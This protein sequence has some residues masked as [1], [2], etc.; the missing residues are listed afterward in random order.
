MPEDDASYLLC[1]EDAGGAIF[2]ATD[3]A[4][5]TCTTA[6]QD[7]GWCTGAESADSFVAEIIVGEADYSPRSD[8]PDRLRSRC[9]DP[10][11]RADSVAWILK[12]TRRKAHTALMN[13]LD[14]MRHACV[15]YFS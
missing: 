10:A 13:F 8:Y 12:V 3:V 11:A 4:A 1:A 2:F 7:D 15:V 6:E 14:W 5:S 9:I